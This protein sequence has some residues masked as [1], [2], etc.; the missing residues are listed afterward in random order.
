[1][2]LGALNE[3][4]EFSAVLMVPGTNVGGYYNTA[5]DLVSNSIGAVIA[6]IAVAWSEW[7]RA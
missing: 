5:L 7:G 3:M 2:G 1:M 6:I 4:I